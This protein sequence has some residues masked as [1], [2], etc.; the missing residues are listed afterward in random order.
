MGESMSIPQL[1]KKIIEQSNRLEKL[2]QRIWKLEPR[3]IIIFAILTTIMIFA[4]N[5]FVIKPWI[6]KG[7]E[8][9]DVDTPTVISTTP[10]HPPLENKKANTSK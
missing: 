4:F 10:I 7:T 9:T 8:K 1:Q 5:Y 3:A 2:E 6:D